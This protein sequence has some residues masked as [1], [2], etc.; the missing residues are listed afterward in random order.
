MKLLTKNML[1]AIIKN[2]QPYIKKH[3]VNAPGVFCSGMLLVL[4]T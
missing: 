3:P 4:E 1:I 2:I